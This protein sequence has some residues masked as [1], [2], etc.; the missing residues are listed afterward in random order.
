MDFYK[1]KMLATQRIYELLVAGKDEFEIS[2]VIGSELG[3]GE[4][5]VKN[6]IEKF[7]KMKER[8]DNEKKNE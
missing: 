3:L 8:K 5:F 1:R 4:K 7:Y 2:F 6:T